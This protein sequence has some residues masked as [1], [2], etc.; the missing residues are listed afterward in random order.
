MVS[1]PD[2]GIWR[3]I[4]FTPE[5]KCAT[6]S[7]VHFNYLYCYDMVSSNGYEIWTVVLCPVRWYWF[8][9]VRLSP[10]CKGWPEN[11]QIGFIS[12]ASSAQAQSL[13][14]PPVMSSCVQP[15]NHCATTLT[16]TQVI[17]GSATSQ[18]SWAVMPGS[19]TPREDSIKN[20]RQRRKCSL[21]GEGAERQGWHFVWT[22]INKYYVSPWWKSQEFVSW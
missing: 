8:T 2:M 21:K 19:T 3:S 17:H 4:W 13:K 6:L 18:R 10:C 20:S 22:F 12:R 16:S 15:S 7:S 5:T 9:P 1:S 14:L 11:S